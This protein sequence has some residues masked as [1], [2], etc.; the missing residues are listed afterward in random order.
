M[1]EQADAPPA[2]DPAETLTRLGLKTGHSAVVG[3]Q[4]GDEGK[5]QIVDVI[6][7][8]FDL[9][10]RYN[11]GNNAGHS[12]HI[13][14]QKFALH[15]VPSGIMYPGRVNVVGNGVVVDPSG[16]LGEIDGLRQRGVAI[17]GDNLRISDRAHVVL[18]Y[19]KVQD[20]LYDLALGKASGDDKKI[21]TTGRGIG[22]CYA[23]KALRST[24]IRMG[25]LRQADHLREKLRHIVQIKNLM[26][27]ALAQQ[28]GEA[29]TPFDANALA[30]EF[31]GHGQRLCEHICDTTRLL[32]GAIA[33]GKRVL[34]EGA[35]ANLLDVD[36]GTYPF[37]TSSN[38]SSL[39]IYPGSGVP[40]GTLTNVIGILKLYTSRVGGGPFPTELHGAVADR[41]R[42][43]GREFG[44]TTGRPRRCGWLDLVATRYAV[45]LSGITALACTGL[46]V[47]AGL[48]TLKVCTGYRQGGNG[49]QTDAFLA[50]ADELAAV[51]PVYRE[52]PGFAGPI[53]HC[54]SFRDLP[55]EARHYIEFIEQQVSVPI[56]M[57]CVGRR[58]DQILVR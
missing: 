6:A 41:I 2:V 47:L 46:S 38:C 20:K 11:G 8:C 51:E 9:V 28:C 44:T 58:R 15:L 52:F 50:D 19:H 14:D 32:H 45:S 17:S 18:P 21:G 29:F 27:S 48:D 13:G 39:G 54:R 7:P 4:F 49:K 31:A 16:I 55:A 53:D 56:R 57:I 35:N 24:A 25:E 3:L 42:E 40:G 5:G 30:D 37:V 12:V 33:D 43:V 22:P 36:H 23:D 10:A 34:F 26:L 1:V